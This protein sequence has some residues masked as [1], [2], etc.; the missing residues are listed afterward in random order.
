LTVEYGINE[1]VE[2]VERGLML[3]RRLASDFSV[4]P[5]CFLWFESDNKLS[6]EGGVNIEKHHRPG[7]LG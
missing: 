5:T 6:I 4:H 3:R 2:L 1:P 7:L